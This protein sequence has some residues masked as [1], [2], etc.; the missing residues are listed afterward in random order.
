MVLNLKEVM[1]VE[2]II[3]III[4]V[5]KRSYL[6]FMIKIN[7]KMRLK[8]LILINLMKTIWMAIIWRLEKLVT[9]KIITFQLQEA[10]EGLISKREEIRIKKV[11]IFVSFKD[12][13]KIIFI[14][15]IWIRK[16]NKIKDQGYFILNSVINKISVTILMN[17]LT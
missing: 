10:K 4:L 5:N 2:V 16:S 6:Q 12:N 9:V 7:E 15:Q 3:M 17:I 1:L 14:C 11:V 8:V 13:R